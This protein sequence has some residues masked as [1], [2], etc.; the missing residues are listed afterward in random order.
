MEIVCIVC[1]KGCRAKVWEESNEIKI[2]GKLCKK[3]KVYVEEEFR[4][5]KRVLTTTV[6]VSNSN[7][8]RVPVRTNKPIPKRLLF[9]CMDFISKVRITPPVEIGNVIVKDILGTGADLIATNEL[10]D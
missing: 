1:P 4:E 10:K 7:I 5:P 2:E 6:A 3:G 9:S 8:K